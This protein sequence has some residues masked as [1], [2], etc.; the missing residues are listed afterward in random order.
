M[1]P[2][3]GV[4]ILYWICTSILAIWRRELRHVMVDR[5]VMV[6]EVEMGRMSRCVILPLRTRLD[7]R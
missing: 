2:V 6:I 7:Q 4:D 3:K 5:V 1:A